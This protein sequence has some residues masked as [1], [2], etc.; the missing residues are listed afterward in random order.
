M[1]KFY[2]GTGRTA[3]PLTRPPSHS[4]TQ[5]YQFVKEL[6]PSIAAHLADEVVHISDP[7]WRSMVATALS[8]EVAD[9]VRPP[10]AEAIAW[11]TTQSG[12]AVPTPSTRRL[13]A[14]TPAESRHGLITTN[15]EDLIARLR[16][17]PS[18]EARIA[19][20]LTLA[21]DAQAVAAAGAE[22]GAVRDPTERAI[23]LAMAANGAFGDLRTRLLRRSL[24]AGRTIRDPTERS[25]LLAHLAHGL[26]GVGSSMIWQEAFR[27]AAN[28]ADPALRA[29][30]L[31]EIID[32]LPQNLRSG[33][34]RDMDTPLLYTTPSIAVSALNQSFAGQA[35]SDQPG[36][37]GAALSAIRSVDSEV[38]R[39]DLLHRMTSQLIRSSAIEPDPILAF[40]FEHDPH[41]AI[42]SLYYIPAARWVEAGRR[43]LTDIIYRSGDS[44]IRS[45][46]VE[47][48]HENRQRSLGPQ[49]IKAAT[50]GT[51]GTVTAL[52]GRDERRVSSR[53]KSGVLKEQPRHVNLWFTSQRGV[54]VPPVP[55]GVNLKAGRAYWLR[56]SIGKRDPRSIVAAARPFPAESLPQRKPA[57]GLRSRLQAATS[58]FRLVDIQYFFPRPGQPG[59]VPA[60]QVLLTLAPG[61]SVNTTWIL[62]SLH[63]TLMAQR[64]CDWQFTATAMSCNLTSSAP[65]FPMKRNMGSAHHHMLTTP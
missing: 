29:K 49:P 58:R 17:L 13:V 9:R 1:D 54:N 42:D 39:K 60:H 23:L 44:D 48:L 35:V 61:T 10:S 22:A 56:L 26:E 57:T 51:R 62:R 50:S 15:R 38:L 2:P 25:K 30:I 7:F 40:A 28:I 6:N 64:V 24:A 43:D 11:V 31:G 27:A 33:I 55:S 21:P 63:R 4:L 20:L 32:S 19:S 36:Y 45:A 53:Q 46:F 5:G 59:C 65:M 8:P 18:P 16:S 37:V 47:T 41:K 34:F 14:S 3:S 12:L 52:T